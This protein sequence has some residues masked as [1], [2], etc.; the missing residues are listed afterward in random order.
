MVTVPLEHLVDLAATYFSSQTGHLLR[1]LQS[2]GNL[3]FLIV[4]E[5][6]PVKHGSEPI[7]RK[8]RQQKSEIDD[9][10]VF[11]TVMS[12][13]PFSTSEQQPRP[14]VVLQLGIEIT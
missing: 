2:F 8:L 9:P 7:S 14:R 1:K 12:K 11:Q 6:Q 4:G 13:Q 3:L 5:V 10:A